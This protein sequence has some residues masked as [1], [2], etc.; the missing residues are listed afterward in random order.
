M[1]TI[2]PKCPK[3]G[4]EIEIHLTI[5]DRLERRIKVLEEELAGIKSHSM[6]EEASIDYLKDVFGIK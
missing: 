6:N 4:H 3:C 2:K 1:K 5:V